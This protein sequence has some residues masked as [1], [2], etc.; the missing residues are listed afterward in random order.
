[1][2]L[3][4]LYALYTKGLTKTGAPGIFSLSFPQKLTNHIRKG[5]CIDYSRLVSAPALNL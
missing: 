3:L 4:L 5:I 1:M 2:L